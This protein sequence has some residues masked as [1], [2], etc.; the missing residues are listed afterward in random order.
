MKLPADNVEGALL[1]A[2]APPPKSG[3]KKR[4]GEFP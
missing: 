4:G 3:P 1:S 2:A